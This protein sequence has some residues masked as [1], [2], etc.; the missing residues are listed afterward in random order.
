MLATS[1][2]NRVLV[3]VEQNKGDGGGGEGAESNSD[4]DRLWM[5]LYHFSGEQLHGIIITI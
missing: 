4:K 3:C 2:W 5:R 1:L